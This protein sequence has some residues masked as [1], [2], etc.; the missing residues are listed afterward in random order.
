MKPIQTILAAV[1]FSVGSRAALD[2]ASHLARLENA[3][4]HILHVVDP[5]AVAAHADKRHQPFDREAQSAMQGAGTALA[6]WIKTSSVPPNVSLTVACGT[7]VDEILSHITTLKADLLVAGI[8]G[9]GDSPTGPGSVSGKLAYRSPVSTLLVRSDHPHPFQKIVSC[10][11]FSDNSPNIAALTCILSRQDQAAVEFLHVW[12]EPW[13]A[14]PHGVPLTD[15]GGAAI[16]SIPGFREDFLRDLRITL[17]AFVAEHAQGIH[18]SAM[19]HEADNHAN[20]IIS[21]ALD[22]G[23]DLIIL[24]DKG[25]SKGFHAL[26]GSTTE[27]LLARLPCSVLV[28]KPAPQTH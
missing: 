24:G 26:L 14:L 12:Q 5:D 28:V 22:S 10:V 4:L 8:A 3:T 17:D 25:R 20:D 21:H 2:Q 18:A 16:A 23:A 27:R 11:D 1:D 15:V 19:L 6:Q 7:P 9:S 13:S